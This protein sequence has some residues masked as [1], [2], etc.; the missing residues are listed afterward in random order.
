MG[1]SW[2]FLP[3]AARL[4]LVLLFDW[5]AV[6]GLILGSFLTGLQVYSHDHVLLV[7]GAILSGCT[8]YA[9]LRLIESTTCVAENFSHL[10]AEKLLLYALAFAVVNSGCYQAPICFL[11]WIPSA[12]FAWLSL[13]WSQGTSSARSWCW[14]PSRSCC[15]RYSLCAALTIPIPAEAR[16]RCLSDLVSR[17]RYLPRHPGLCL[18]L[19]YTTARQPSGRGGVNAKGA[20]MRPQRRAIPGWRAP[21]SGAGRT[22]YGAL[23]PQVMW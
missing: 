23:S 8:P 2:I 12:R 19:L 13:P 15:G 5:P 1:V 18:Y 4:L 9:T 7:V 21:V 6:I 3:S 22:G 17:C 10:T 11:E 16:R 20:G 14:G